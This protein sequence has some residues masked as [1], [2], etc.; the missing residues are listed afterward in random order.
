MINSITVL[1]LICSFVLS[2]LVGIF[3]WRAKA[4]TPGG[5]LGA[6]IVG[7]MIFAFGGWAWAALLFTFFISSSVLSKSF[8]KQKIKVSDKFCKGSQ[9]DLGQVLAN[10]GAGTLIVVMH[11]LYPDQIWPWIAFT[12][13]MATVNGDTWATE[14][15]V[16]SRNLPKLITTGRPV[17]RGTSGGVS[18]AG[19]LA[20]LAGSGLLSLVMALFGGPAASA[21]GICAASLGG[22]MGAFIDSLL[23]AAVQAVY[24]DPGLGK[25]T[26]RYIKGTVPI[27][28]WAWINNDVVNLISSVFGALAAAGLWFLLPK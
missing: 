4:L 20:A 5:S 26:E 17:D 10:G 19:S 24:Y 12:G 23:G 22:V 11:V 3:A 15:G 18:L 27:R 7:G 21:A 8:R 28:G 13:A 6:F 16:L 1:S 25:Q 2:G 9:R 14:L